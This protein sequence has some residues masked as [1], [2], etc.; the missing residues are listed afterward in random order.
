MDPPSLAP[1]F[2]TVAY[3]VTVQHERLEKFPLPP[4]FLLTVT[5]PYNREITVT[6]YVELERLEKILAVEDSWI[7][8]TSFPPSH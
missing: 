8:V 4:Y 6:R 2:A 3:P 7:Q 5:H 1:P